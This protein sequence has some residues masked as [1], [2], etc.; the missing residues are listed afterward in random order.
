M[1]FIEKITEKLL[2]TNYED[3]TSFCIT[4]LSIAESSLSFDKK[5]IQR[6][7]W[8]IDNTNENLQTSIY[9]LDRFVDPS[10]VS[11]DPTNYSFQI[12]FTSDK[13]IEEGSD[14]RQQIKLK[15]ED[16]QK[17][18]CNAVQEINRILYK[19][20]SLYNEDYVMPEGMQTNDEDDFN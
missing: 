8:I 13:L 15:T 1:K 16:L 2:I 17:H 6:I 7:K 19:Y 11:D 9:K 14:T 4:A 10:K 20:L 18:M 3:F 5:D 12:T